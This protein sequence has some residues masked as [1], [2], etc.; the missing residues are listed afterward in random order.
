M[1]RVIERDMNSDDS[2]YGC[3]PEQ[4]GSDLHNMDACSRRHML[5]HRY[6]LESDSLFYGWGVVV[7]GTQSPPEILVG[8]SSS[9]PVVLRPY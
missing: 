4:L 2:H 3:I 6:L 1:I 5:S 8:N 9:P 7:G